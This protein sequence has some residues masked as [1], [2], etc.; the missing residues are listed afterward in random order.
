MSNEFFAISHRI[1]GYIRHNY[2][3]NITYIL[4]LMVFPSYDNPEGFSVSS[5]DVVIYVKILIEKN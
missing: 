2:L 4:F 1:T 5:K 3:F